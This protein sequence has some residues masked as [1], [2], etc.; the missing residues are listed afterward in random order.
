MNRRN[1]MLTAGVT[2]IAASGTNLTFAQESKGVKKYIELRV[3]TVSSP[4]KK[5]KLIEVFD[6]ALIPALNRQG[7]K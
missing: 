1:F 5:E 3:Y 6:K 4:E 7:S 2:G